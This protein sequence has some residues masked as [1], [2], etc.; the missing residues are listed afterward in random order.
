M[1]STDECIIALIAKKGYS[2]SE[3]EGRC[4][5]ISYI[6]RFLHWSTVHFIK[7]PDHH[8]EEEKH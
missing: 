3:K 4:G 7:N 1:E 2:K 8:P 5:L 6:I